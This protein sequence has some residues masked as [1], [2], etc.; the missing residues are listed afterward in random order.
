VSTGAS[1]HYPPARVM[2]AALGYLLDSARRVHGDQTV[3]R[4]F[5]RRERVPDGAPSIY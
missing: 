3:L 4:A 2:D 5:T 1:P